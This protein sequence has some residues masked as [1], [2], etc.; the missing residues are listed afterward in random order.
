MLSL[1]EFKCKEHTRRDGSAFS[2]NL[3]RTEGLL[4][5][6]GA[7]CGEIVSIL[8]CTTDRKR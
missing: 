1:G 4:Q 6:L 5:P 7:A 3:H 8:I 2:E